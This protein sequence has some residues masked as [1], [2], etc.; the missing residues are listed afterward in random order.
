MEPRWRLSCEENP[1]PAPTLGN[2]AP[3]DVM[4]SA[5]GRLKVAR[6]LRAIDRGVYL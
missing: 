4:R 2:K 5:A 3:L 6:I 1:L